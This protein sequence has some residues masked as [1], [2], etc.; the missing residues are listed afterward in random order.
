MRRRRIIWHLFP[1][2]VSVTLVALAV[3][4]WHTLGALREVYYDHVSADLSARAHLIAHQLPTP[5]A[6]AEPRAIDGLCKSLGAASGTRVTVILPPGKVVGD[7]DEDPAAMDNHADRPEVARALAGGTG[8]STR[9]SFSLEQH[10]KYVAIPILEGGSVVGVV[11]TSVPLSGIGQAL[12]GVRSRVVAAGLLLALLAALTSLF[13]SRRITRPLVELREA[14][15][16]FASGDLEHRIPPQ[17]SAE[18]SALA[19][20]M[21]A[22]AVQLGQRLQTLARQGGEQEALLS[23]MI[24]GVVAVDAD[25]RV[26]TVNRAA[27]EL[28]GINPDEARG[29]ALQ[30]TIRHPALQRLV[31]QTLETDQVVEAELVVQREGERSLQAHGTRLHGVAGHGDAA[32][33]VLNDVTRLHRLEDVRRDFVANVSHELR[34]P[35]TSIKGFVETLRDGAMQRPEDGERFLGIIEKQADRLNA[36]IEDLLALSRIEEGEQSGRIALEVAPLRPILAAA[37]EDCEPKAAAKEVTLELDCSEDIAARIDGALLEQAVLNLIDN[38][39]KHSPKEGA[40]KVRA[41]QTNDEV[42]VQVE[43][44]GCGIHRQHLSRIFERFYRVDRA[45]SRRLGGTG[46]GL[47]IVKHIT[48]AHGGRVAVES[49]PGQG[50]TFSIHLP[51][52]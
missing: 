47:A 7:S 32:L 51:R 19:D 34:T 30:E 40:V 25:R 8:D 35:V 17:T 41:A 23:S 45:R 5:L 26:I 24:E 3:L 18:A 27:G 2:A 15:E 33:I 20:A 46:L 48:Q 21:N 9:Y 29:R 13:I 44:E 14:A 11:R 6:S 43:D 37:I 42:T 4:G 52:A 16:R 1:A 12:S 36:I 31:D 39:I 50:S 28:F 38:A 10:M 22:M 49:A